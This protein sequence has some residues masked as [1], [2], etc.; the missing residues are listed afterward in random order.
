MSSL[1]INNK[2]NNRRIDQGSSQ[3]I[4]K[5]KKKGTKI[6]LI[7]FLCIVLI[8]STIVGLFYTFSRRR[9]DLNI[10]FPGAKID[11]F[12]YES[13]KFAYDLKASFSKILMQKGFANQSYML[14]NKIK[15]TTAQYSK[16]YN[17]KDQIELLEFYVEQ[18]EKKDFMNLNAKI[19]IEFKN[20]KGL[21]VTS[22]EQ[23]IQNGQDTQDEQTL[24]TTQYDSA[25]IKTNEQLSYCKV[26]LEGYHMF[27]DTK[28]LEQAK[29]LA[30]TIYEFFKVSNLPPAEISLSVL[31]PISVPDFS[32]TPIPKPSLSPT[33]DINNT[34]NINVIN[35]ADIDLYAL[36]VLSGIDSKW[37]PVFEKTL[38][39]VEKSQ[40]GAEVALFNAGYDVKNNSYIPYL[41]KGPE[42]ITK[43]QIQIALNLAQVDKTNEK[44]L[45]QLKQLLYNS[46]AFYESYQIISNKAVNEVESLAS[47]ALMARIARI[48]KDK[49]LYDLCVDKMKWNTATNK[50]SYI[51]ALPFRDNDDNEI[52]A[53]SYDAVLMMK[54]IF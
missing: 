32:A 35:L 49:E 47:Y 18:N 20:S 16:F 10:T 14:E 33:P 38:G 51:Y 39:I 26:L 6:G 4:K 8:T 34:T 48:N 1:Y 2:K 31:N 50:N 41:S 15:D 30:N 52:I 3:R 11:N 22:L 19:V 43:N 36:K 9:A 24:I 12:T 37:L 5:T 44:I 13:E 28:L 7:V 53:Y 21:Y 27:G 29:T 45:A 54:S 40:I 23:K 42:F 17:L 46:N 25:I